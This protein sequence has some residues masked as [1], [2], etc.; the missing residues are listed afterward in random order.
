MLTLDSPAFQ[1]LRRDFNEW[2]PAI[3]DGRDKFVPAHPGM[4]TEEDPAEQRIERIISLVASR[5]ACTPREITG[6]RRSVAY[7]RPRFI[8]YLLAYEMVPDASLPRIGRA[9]GDRDH[10][11]IMHGI[12]VARQSI[13]ENDAWREFY[14]KVKAAL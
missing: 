5:A 4:A 6:P 12:K 3:A 13:A 1:E 8:G 7:S 11:T 9:F 2:L 10:T 14:E